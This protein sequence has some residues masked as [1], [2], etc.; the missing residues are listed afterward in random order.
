MNDGE[1]RLLARIV[2]LAITKGLPQVI[3]LIGIWS[4]DQ[5]ELTSEKILALRDRLED[6]ESFFE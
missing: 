6:P 2:E 3:K 4:T 1:A 5:G